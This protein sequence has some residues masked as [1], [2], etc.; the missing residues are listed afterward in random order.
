MS[1]HRN[2]PVRRTMTT[3][4]N[5]KA[6]PFQHVTTSAQIESGPFTPRTQIKLEPVQVQ[7]DGFDASSNPAQLAQLLGGTG[8]A[9]PGATQNGAALP[10]ANPELRLPEG[11]RCQLPNPHPSQVGVQLQKD[12]RLVVRGG[13]GD[14]EVGLTQKNGT[15]FVTSGKKALASFPAD[16][17]KSIDVRTGA[18]NDRVT[19]TGIDAGIAR[20][21]TGAGQD[22]VRVRNSR[23]VK[24]STGSGNDSVEV[25]H[26]KNVRVHTGSGDDSVRS[27]RNQNLHARLGDGRDSLVDHGSNRLYAHGGNGADTFRLYH[28]NNAHID[29]GKGGPALSMFPPGGPMRPIGSSPDRTLIHGGKNVTTQN[30]N[31]YTSSPKPVKPPVLPGKVKTETPDF[32]SYVSKHRDLE[33]AWQDMRGAGTTA[34]NNG[35]Y[36]KAFGHGLS[37]QGF[38]NE[39]NRLGGKQIS[40]I[41]QLS[42]EEWGMLHYQLHGQKEGRKLPSKIVMEAPTADTFSNYVLNNPDLRLAYRAMS[43][44]GTLTDA[45]M[46]EY[47]A[48]YGKGLNE[49]HFIDGWNRLHPEKSIT[50]LGQLSQS[51]WGL[52]HYHLHGRNEG[53]SLTQSVEQNLRLRS[54]EQALRL[55]VAA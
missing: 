7:K 12:G 19:L 44:D 27:V 49:K 45:Q 55:S 33:L 38:I 23:N 18:G 48:T 17:V 39:W 20:V 29:G 24:I 14:D 30:T 34:A 54:A 13:K 47:K 2:K 16:R 11:F 52:L 8:P 9:A 25:R 32:G 51:Q 43:R 50:D 1:T 41:G 28:S 37:E 3:I 53:R 6:I 35:V 26:S 15:I 21:A 42:K 4:K 36:A 5:N 31:V 22:Q 46:N 10:K 40:D